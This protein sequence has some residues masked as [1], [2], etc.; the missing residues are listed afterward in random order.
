MKRS[1]IKEVISHSPD[2]TQAIGT[3]WGKELQHGW[4]LGLKGELGTGKTQLVKGLARALGYTGKVQSPTFA[5]LNEY[6]AD[7]PIYHID[8]YRLDTRAQIIGAG[9]EHFFYRPN[10]IAVIEWIERWLDNDE[11]FTNLKNFRF[12]TIEQHSETDCR[13]TY[14]DFGA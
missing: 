6:P 11:E 8:L 14:E 3:S 7:T 13:I 4:V 12:A 5:L 2:E 9:L 1:G 10:G